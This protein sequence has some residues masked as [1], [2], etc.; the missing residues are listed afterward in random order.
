M[1]GQTQVRFG[2]SIGLANVELEQSSSL[3]TLVEEW[4]MLDET[5]LKEALQEAWIEWVWETISGGADIV[6]D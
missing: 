6:E 1:D 4:E 5:G 2:L 3:D